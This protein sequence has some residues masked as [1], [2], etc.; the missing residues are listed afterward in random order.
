M[1]KRRS[2]IEPA[3]SHIKTDGKLDQN[4]LEGGSDDSM[5]AVLRDAGI[6]AG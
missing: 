1:I 6:T 2:A 5:H 4:W 3:I